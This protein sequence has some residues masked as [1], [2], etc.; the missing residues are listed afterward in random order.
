MDDRNSLP[1]K[2]VTRSIIVQNNNGNGDY[3]GGP[4]FSG[5]ERPG[6]PGDIPMM[7]SASVAAVAEPHLLILRWSLI[8]SLSSWAVIV[9]NQGGFHY[10]TT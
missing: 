2:N 6:D 1:T 7:G 5:E 10:Q 3:G 9:A 8:P 4:N